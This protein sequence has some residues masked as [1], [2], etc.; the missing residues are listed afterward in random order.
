[1][2]A[3]ALKQQP[4]VVA[5]AL[6]RAG[7]HVVEREQPFTD[8]WWADEIWTIESLWSPQGA[9]AFLTFATIDLDHDLKYLVATRERPNHQ[10]ISETR[11]QMYLGRGWQN[12]LP[13]F[14]ESLGEFRS[15]IR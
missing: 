2:T 14:V 15:Q 4:A 10:A 8:E 9:R 7:W 3:R 5:A 11:S 6:E 13:G 12:E 1:M